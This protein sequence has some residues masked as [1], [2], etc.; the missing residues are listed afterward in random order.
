MLIDSE[1]ACQVFGK[2]LG[3]TLSIELAHRHIHSYSAF[4]YFWG[5][6][7]YLDSLTSPRWEVKTLRFI[8]E[9]TAFSFIAIIIK[10]FIYWSLILF[11]HARLESFSFGLRV[12]TSHNSFLVG[13]NRDGR[14]QVS[15]ICLFL[16]SLGSVGWGHWD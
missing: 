15:I 16:E 7:S 1:G 13:S 3:A 8:R 4:N 10:F 14:V 2:L 12:F 11:A 9:N 5:R 6:S